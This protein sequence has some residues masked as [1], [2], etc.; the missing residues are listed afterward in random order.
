MSFYEDIKKRGQE[1]AR[2]S[3]GYTPPESFTTEAVSKGDQAVARTNVQTPVAE[4]ATQQEQPNLLDVYSNGAYSKLQKQ[5]QEL[6]PK[7]KTYTEMVREMYP[8]ISEEEKKAQEK[9]YK[10]RQVVNAIG[11]GISALSN[12]Y[13]TNKSGVNAE[14][15]SYLTEAARKRYDKFLDEQRAYAEKRKDLLLRSEEL[16]AAAELQRLRQKREDDRYADSRE[17]IK[18]ARDYAREQDELNR[19]EREKA[20]KIAQDNANRQFEFNENQARISNALKKEYQDGVL[21]TKTRQEEVKLANDML[22]KPFVID[23]ITVYQR[24]WDKNWPAIYRKLVE[25]LNPESE[26]GKR[27]RWAD[28]IDKTYKTTQQKQQ[29]LLERAKSSPNVLA[30][31]K[32]LAALTPEWLMNGAK[33]GDVIDYTPG[34]GNIIEYT[35]KKK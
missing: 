6:Q 21:K 5:E 7:Q 35:P 29:F 25:E 26:E 19:K 10:T 23:G 33:G 13:Y 8:E 30:A 11:D 20:A 9:K 17:D 12:L 24:V 27:K 15:T 32:E 34:G 22:G 1:N 31:I 18:V 28:N 14:P 4:A 2:V 16:D 3:G